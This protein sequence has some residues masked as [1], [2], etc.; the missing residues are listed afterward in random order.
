MSV[1]ETIFEMEPAVD[2]R[3][4]WRLKQVVVKQEFCEF[5]IAAGQFPTEIVVL[6]QFEY[7]GDA[8]QLGKR[9]VGFGSEEDVSGQKLCLVFDDLTGD[10][11]LRVRVGATASTSVIVWLM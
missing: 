11:F 10:G 1:K 4:V 6:Q 7:I 8:G 5:S 2:K 9:F 3:N